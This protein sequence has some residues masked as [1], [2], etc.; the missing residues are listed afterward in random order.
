MYNCQVIFVSFCLCYNLNDCSWECFLSLCASMINTGDANTFSV[1]V[2]FFQVEDNPQ[3]D[4]YQVGFVIALIYLLVQ[5]L[6]Q[7]L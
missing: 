3:K 2:Q 7:V 5:F 1:L 6:R 4:L